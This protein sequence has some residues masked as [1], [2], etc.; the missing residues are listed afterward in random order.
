MP[1]NRWQVRAPV[2]PPSSFHRCLAQELFPCRLVG[3]SS[4]SSWC[5]VRQSLGICSTSQRVASMG[6]RRAYNRLSAQ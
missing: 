5:N 4:A 2:P 1:A 3:A 6:A